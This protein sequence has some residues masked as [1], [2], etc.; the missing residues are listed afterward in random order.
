[1]THDPFVAFCR[2]PGLARTREAATAR[3]EEFDD[4]LDEEADEPS[5]EDRIDPQ[6]FLRWQASL[7]RPEPAAG[8]V[9][10]IQ[11]VLTGTT[12]ARGRYPVMPV[13]KGEA[14]AWLDPAGFE[15]AVTQVRARIGR[16]PSRSDYE[17]ITIG[18]EPTVTRLFRPA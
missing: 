15:L 18:G 10:Q 12:G 7:P 3:R 14:T 8:D 17:L 11:V 5:A 9:P 6:N 2:A 13:K 16:R 1:G 4:W